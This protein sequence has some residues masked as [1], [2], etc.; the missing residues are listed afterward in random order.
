MSRC[1]WMGYLAVVGVVVG[2]AACGDYTG[3]TS[4]PLKK[5][6][7]TAP[8][9]AVYSRYI[10][11]SGVWTCVEGCD[12]EGDAKVEGSPPVTD[13]VRV[14]SLPADAPPTEAPPAEEP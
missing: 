8:T 7:L 9:G 3:P 5:I 2:L 12:D 6:N 14:D 10:L 4:P 1:R 11:I 13:S